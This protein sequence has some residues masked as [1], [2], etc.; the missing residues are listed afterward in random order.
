[1]SKQTGRAAMPRPRH[2]EGR[3]SSLRQS[4]NRDQGTR[5]VAPNEQ[6]LLKGRD[7]LAARAPNVIKLYSSYRA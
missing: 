7:V 4:L 2:P 6:Q 5:L 1:M 3:T